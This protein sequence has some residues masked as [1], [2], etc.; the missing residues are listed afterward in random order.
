MKKKKLTSKD[1]K[2]IDTMLADFILRAPKNSKL[3][4][5]FASFKE[6]LRFHRLA[7]M[8]EERFPN[9]L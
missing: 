2:K 3:K 8:L 9:G 5:E 6:R 4:E 7:T 1:F